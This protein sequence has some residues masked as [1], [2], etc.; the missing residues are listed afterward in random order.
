MKTDKTL[1]MADMRTLKGVKV[2]ETASALLYAQFME[3]WV[4]NLRVYMGAMNSHLAKVSAKITGKAIADM[5][6][7]YGDSASKYGDRRA[8]PDY[9]D[10]EELRVTG[11]AGPDGTKCGMMTKKVK[12]GYIYTVPLTD[13]D[14]GLYLTKGTASTLL[15]TY[16]ERAPG[17]TYDQQ[18]AA[19]GKLVKTLIE[20]VVG[21]EFFDTHLPFY[22]EVTLNIDDALKGTNFIDVSRIQK[23][24]DAGDYN[25]SLDEDATQDI[26]RQYAKLMKDS[27]QGFVFMSPPVLRSNR[28]GEF[29]SDIPH[30]EDPTGVRRIRGVIYS[31]DQL[32]LLTEDEKWRYYRWVSDSRGLIVHARV[33]MPDKVAEFVCQKPGASLNA[34]HVGRY[35]NTR[36]IKEN[37]DDEIPDTMYHT[38]LDDIRDLNNSTKFMGRERP[39]VNPKTGLGVTDS[40]TPIYIPPKLD[41]ID[42]YE[43]AQASV[44]QKT[45]EKAYYQYDPLATQENLAIVGH[46]TDF[47]PRSPLNLPAGKLLY[48]DWRNAV[49]AYV[50]SNQTLVAADISAYQPMTPQMV[51]RFLN[52]QLTLTSG[53]GSRDV[54]AKEMFDYTMRHRGLEPKKFADNYREGFLNIYLLSVSIL[55]TQEKLDYY[56]LDPSFTTLWTNTI[57]SMDFPTSWMRAA[58]NCEVMIDRAV[59]YMGTLSANGELPKNLEDLYKNLDDHNAET[60]TG[61]AI[62]LRHL[63]GN[64]PNIILACFHQGIVEVYRKYKKNF[65][66]FTKTRSIPNALEE[67]G[68]IAILALYSETYSAL[69]KSV[70][71][72]VALNKDRSIPPEDWNPDALPSAKDGFTLMP[73]QGKIDYWNTRSESPKKILNVKAG[74]GKTIS[75]LL[76]IQ[77]LMASKKIKRPLVMCPGY[78]MKNYIEDAHF[79]FEGRLNVVPIDTP[80]VRN[81]SPTPGD[82]QKLGLDGIRDMVKTAPPNTLF[83]T[84]YDFISKAPVEEFSYGSTVVAFNPHVDLLLECDFDYVGADESHELRNSTSGKHQWA[85]VIFSYA[86]MGTLATGTLLNTRPEDIPMQAKMLDP[87]VFGTVD[88][89]L[90]EYADNT[91]GGRLASFRNLGKEDMKRNLTEAFNYIQVDRKEW[92]ALLPDRKDQWHIIDIDATGAHKFLRTLYDGVLKRVLEEIK[93]EVAK[94]KVFQKALEADKESPTEDNAQLETLLR[95]YLQRLEQLLMS[96]QRDP[97]FAKLADTVNLP[98]SPKV[99]KAIQICNWHLNGAS[100]GELEA[101][102]SDPSNEGFE[103]PID[104]EVQKAG[105]ITPIP[106]KILILCTYENSVDAIYEALP[107]NLKNQAIRYSAMDKDKALSEYKTNPEKRILIGIGTSLSTGH[108]LQ[109]TTRIIRLEGIWSPGELEQAESRMNRPDP[110]AGKTAQRSTIYYDWI[111]LNGTIDITKLSRLTSRILLNSLIEEQDNPAYKRVQDLPLVS[112]TLEN[113]ENMSWLIP[114]SRRFEY[115]AAGEKNLYRYLVELN[116]VMKIRQD[117]YNQYK[118]DPNN[119]NEDYPVIPAPTPD[120]AEVMVGIPFIPGQNVP[121]MKELGLL[122]YNEYV[123]EKSGGMLDAISDYQTKGLRVYT[124]QGLGTITGM[125]ATSVT[126]LL[127]SGEKVRVNKLC[128]FVATSPD[129]SNA[130]VVGATGLLKARNIK[131]QPIDIKTLVGKKSKKSLIK[132]TPEEPPVTPPKAPKQVTKKKEP[133]PN[134]DVVDDDNVQVFAQ[135]YN[136]MVSLVLDLDDPTVA[137]Y[138]KWFTRQGFSYNGSFVYAEVR[139]FR[140]YDNLLSALSEKYDIPASQMRKLDRYRELFSQGRTRLLSIEQATKSEMMAFYLRKHRMQPVGTILPYA[141]IEDDGFYLCIDLENSPSAKQVRSVKVPGITWEVETPSLRVMLNSKSEAV[142]LLKK[143]EEYVVITNKAEVKDDLSAIKLTKK[144]SK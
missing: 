63:T 91:A 111:A 8:F 56:R 86:D 50:E 77:R 139:N 98:V 80:N 49:L 25:L 58:Q 11:L 127:D 2:E 142:S 104:E 37:A 36:F 22:K 40:G 33:F 93:K 112:M 81:Y 136:N 106:G 62:K 20:E 7:E 96:P 3:L 34:S 117:D 38:Q 65:G 110:K 131:G 140:Q 128:T 21:A 12:G 87:T 129:I 67:F 17:T 124:T 135:A 15:G 126:V 52:R 118:N 88:D 144:S 107:P 121:K 54:R 109:M 18:L 141:I 51:H 94:N 53:S 143:L 92:A 26:V 89:F 61:V 32:S 114:P 79:V 105:G 44:E 10:F 101:H 85:Q 100:V 31:R 78:L 29:T 71:A 75:I 30:P 122:R 90:S 27:F 13:V 130:S 28:N 39:R 68:Y 74:G 108:N 69:D 102:N 64:S 113:I 134:S 99:T 4:F 137:R 19:D 123:N 133:I 46:N 16:I 60:R 47:R 66:Q 138:R 116:K 35:V 103:V 41:D 9:D 23:W 125:N 73:H 132:D 76:D 48:V 72:V 83:V 24:L 119:R 45:P 59:R 57:N 82:S 120:D 14:R 84:S 43:G 5:R 95:P 42:E 70:G 97:D 115:S 1:E 6:D 55:P